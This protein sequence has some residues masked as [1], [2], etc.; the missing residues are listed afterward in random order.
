[1][2]DYD[3]D[4]AANIQGAPNTEKR[5]RL[6]AD[7]RSAIA[8]AE[9]NMQEVL[10]GKTK[11]DLHSELR[12]VNE[13]FLDVK[14]T[15]DAALD[16]KALLLIAEMSSYKVQR[17]NFGGG[18]FTLEDFVSKVAAR[19]GGSEQSA[20]RDHD[21]ASVHS[22]N[23]DNLKW[24]A[25]AETIARISTRV[26]IP[27]FMYGAIAVEPKQREFK[28]RTAKLVKDGSKLRQPEQ[29]AEED[30]VQQENETSSNVQLIYRCLEQVQPVNFFKF[31][32]NPDSFSQSVENLFYLSFLVHDGLARLEDKNGKLLLS[33]EV[34]PTESDLQRGVTKLQ[35]I[36]SLDMKTWKD[37]I[38][39]FDITK[40]IIPTRVSHSVKDNGKWYG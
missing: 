39:T 21:D 16:S 5:R 15:Q 25:L 24:D 36:L 18:S 8:Q 30:I 9:E 11:I 10:N 34:P 2:S 22:L 32:I 29:L 37:A 3:S 28:R 27:G 17:L 7:Y 12:Q 4:D 14:A 35:H 26:C 23:S 31:F 33:T 6:R 13:L 38:E 40:P 20:V 19:L 1:M